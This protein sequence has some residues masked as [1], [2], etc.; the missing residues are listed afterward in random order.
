MKSR[1]NKKEQIEMIDEEEMERATKSITLAIAILEKYDITEYSM[2]SKKKF[3][4]LVY[5]L[6]TTL[7]SRS[8]EILCEW[9]E[10]EKF[11]LELQKLES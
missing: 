11:E 9:V 10:S 3:A 4:G 2:E 7:H 6:V 8:M 1:L 5:E